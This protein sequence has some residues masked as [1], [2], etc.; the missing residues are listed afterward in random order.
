MS[1]QDQ[2]HARK[3]I[4]TGEWV[5]VSPHRTLRPWQGQTEDPAS[6]NHAAY[7]PTCYL[8]A[9]NE[10]ANGECNPDYEGPFIFDNDFPALSNQ[11][12]IEASEGQLFQARS[13]SGHCRVVCFSE[14]HNQRLSTMAEADVAAALK[15]MF[16]DFST[17][18]GSGQFDYV[19][20]FENRG[21]MMGCSNQHPHAQIWATE[22]L[23]T[24]PAKELNAQRS[25]HAE[26]GS[27]LLLDYLAA[28]I[29]DGAR[30]VCSNERFVS[31]VPYW[32]T[33]P[34]EQLL[35]PRRH[36]TSPTE[37]DDDDIESLA[38]ILGRALRAND[39]LFDT[40][41]PYS[42]GFH[43]APCKGSHPQWQFH[44]HI[45]PPLLRS[46]TIKKHLVGFELLGM[47]QRDLTP[48][49]AAERLRAAMETR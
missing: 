10:R 15:A 13:E 9:G 18:S 49:V 28:E 47:P 40:S 30:L 37:F 2:S 35:L 22:N 29:E 25:H 7:D 6:N 21:E 38:A 24:E 23:P 17:L 33:W 8:C 1:M 3:N 42:M 44:V 39:R 34:F 26:S 43:A 5:L 11:S 14:Q 41:A 45:Y 48:E 12:E 27:V 4:L 32:A 46:A 20:I 31:L 19:Q 36:V 16:A